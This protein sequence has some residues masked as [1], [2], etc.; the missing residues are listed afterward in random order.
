MS[1]SLR[2]RIRRRESGATA[3]EYAIMATGIAL[4]VIAAV[5][6]IGADVRDIFANFANSL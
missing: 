6:L 3:A 2:L 1:R 4:V 5:T